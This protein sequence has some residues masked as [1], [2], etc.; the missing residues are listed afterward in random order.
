MA[1]PNVPGIPYT[2]T[3]SYYAPTS[4]KTLQEKKINS[5][6]PSRRATE[7]VPVVLSGLANDEGAKEVEVCEF[8]DGTRSAVSPSDSVASIPTGGKRGRKKWFRNP[9]KSRSVPVPPS[10]PS[11][12]STPS[13]LSPSPTI[14]GDQAAPTAPMFSFSRRSKKR[15]RGQS[16]QPQTMRSRTAAIRESNFVEA[17]YLAALLR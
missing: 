11:A 5:T 7:P 13:S 8:A 10:V 14:T 12:P 16:S 3:I 1:S 17:A 6:S 15:D 9:F 2:G 4:S